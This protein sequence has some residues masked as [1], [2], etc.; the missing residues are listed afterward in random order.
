MS[1][2]KE[3]IQENHVTHYVSGLMIGAAVDVVADEARSNFRAGASF[4]IDCAD[5]PVKASAQS[6]IQRD[7]ESGFTKTVA[8]GRLHKTKHGY[9]IIT[10]AVLAHILQP[11]TSLLQKDVLCRA[12]MKALKWYT[13]Q[14][15]DLKES[16]RM[17]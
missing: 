17:I 5:I 10:Q 9:E 2:C 16:K 3:Y 15:T 4:G 7:R 13:S 14:A 8:T 1:L 6:G 11:I 12:M